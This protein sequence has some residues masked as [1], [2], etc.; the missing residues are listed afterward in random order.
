MVKIIENDN[1]KTSLIKSASPTANERE[2]KNMQSAEKN[3]KVNSWFVNLS[4][5]ITIY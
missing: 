2:I 4:I 3:F 5:A 1:I